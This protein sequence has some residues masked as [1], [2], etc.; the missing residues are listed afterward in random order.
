VF[1]KQGENY[2]PAE[3]KLKARAAGAQTAEDRFVRNVR[4]VQTGAGR[5]KA[6]IVGG[7]DGD[8]AAAAVT[9]P[10][11]RQEW[12]SVS[13]E[14]WPSECHCQCRRHGPHAECGCAANLFDGSSRTPGRSIHAWRLGGV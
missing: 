13:S 3:A 8:G 10:G 7:P 11:P 1:R 12:W 2:S 4:S 6:E 9:Q 5:A 14:V